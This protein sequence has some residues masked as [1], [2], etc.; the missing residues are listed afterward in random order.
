MGADRPDDPDV[1]PDRRDD[2]DRSGDPPAHPGNLQAE[3]RTRHQ[4]Y[5]DLRITVS[6]EQSATAQQ[7]TAEEQATADNWQEKSAESRCMWTEYQHKWP[8]SER[9]PV[10]RSVDDAANGRIEMECDRIVEREREKISPAL[11]AIESQDPD[12]HRG[13]GEPDR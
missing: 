13:R 1:P 12:R 7:V 11:R 2:Q 3:T 9:P 10:R 4:Y 6:R 8:T 5:A